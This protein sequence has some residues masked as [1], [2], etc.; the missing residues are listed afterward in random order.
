[1][2]NSENYFISVDQ[3]R[4]KISQLIQPVTGFECKSLMQA[5]NCILDEDILATFATP[6][7]DNS[8]M[9]GYAI[10]FDNQDLEELSSLELIGTSSAGHP[11]DKTVNTGQVVRIMTGAKVPEGANAVIMQEKTAK[12]DDGNIKILNLPKIGENIRYTGEDLQSGDTILSK[13]KQLSPT[14]LAYLATQGISNVTVKRKLRAAFFSTG[15]ELCS[16]GEALGEGQ[17]YD[18]NRYSIFG[19]LTNMGLDVM[20]MGI[21]KDDRQAIEQ[22]FMQAAEN[23]DLVITSGGVS[24]GDADYVK[25][26]LEKLGNIDFWKISMKPGKPLAFGKLNNTLFF[27]LP[28]NPVAVIATFYQIAQTAIKQLSGQTPRFDNNKDSFT[29]LATTDQLIKKRPGR[30]DFQRGIFSSDNDGNVTVK[31]AGTQA[32]HI[33]TSM[34]KANCFIVLDKDQGS[35][36]A[37]KTVKIQPFYGL[38]G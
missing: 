23:A 35:V 20:D 9:D 38:L 14:D 15:D 13:G 12:T 21:I 34:S 6:P 18:S 36:E 17:I 7:Y 28:G 4:D 8:A 2:D 37:G 25:E 26:T 5:L 27:G 29:I 24:V 22:A 16:M 11:F 3:A 1:M 19:M 33:L 31:L 32:S 30:T 10:A